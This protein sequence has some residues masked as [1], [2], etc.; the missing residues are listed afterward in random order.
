MF[1]PFLS[2]V[3]VTKVRRDCDWLASEGL[4]DYSL[5]VGSRVLLLHGPRYHEFS[6]PFFV[7]AYLPRFK[8]MFIYIFFR[9]KEYFCSFLV[10]W[11]LSRE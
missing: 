3:H 1:T 4:M 7:H 9:E 2:P 8:N 11:Y 5:L 6:F 10:F